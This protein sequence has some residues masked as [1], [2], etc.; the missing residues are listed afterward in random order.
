VANKRGLFSFATLSDLDVS[1]DREYAIESVMI[2]ETKAID[3]WRGRVFTV[4]RTSGKHGVVVSI[5][6]TQARFHV[7]AERGR[8]F[9][10]SCRGRV[11]GTPHRPYDEADATIEFEEFERDSQT[12]RYPDTAY[13]GEFG[14]FPKHSKDRYSSTHFHFSLRHIPEDVRDWLVPLMSYE[15]GTN[16]ILRVRLESEEK[17]LLEATEELR[18]NVCSYE[19]EVARPLTRTTK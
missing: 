4:R 7:S 18:G 14:Y 5:H 16:V 3:R 11:I 2:A 1:T 12:F 6:L 9:S 10:I 8:L 17:E 19:F 15:T 13:F